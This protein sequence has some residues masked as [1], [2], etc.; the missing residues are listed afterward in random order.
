MQHLISVSVLHGAILQNAQQSI[1]TEHSVSLQTRP[2]LKKSKWSAQLLMPAILPVCRLNLKA[3]TA[4]RGNREVS[5]PALCRWAQNFFWGKSCKYSFK[6]T[7]SLQFIV[8]FGLLIQSYDPSPATT[9][10]S[11]VGIEA[12]RAQDGLRWYLPC[13]PRMV[14][15]DVDLWLGRYLNSE[16][17]RFWEL[18]WQYLTLHCCFTKTTRHSLGFSQSTPPWLAGD[19]CPHQTRAAIKPTSSLQLQLSSEH[20]WAE[21]IPSVISPFPVHHPT[22]QALWMPSLT[23]SGIECW[24]LNNF[25]P[26]SPTL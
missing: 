7:S 22:A 9:K 24:V 18:W 26:R 14:V 2:N 1:L 8:T 16:I 11:S 20:Y 19:S 17:T 3:S 5:L 15:S 21:G 25:F 23:P 6:S 13:S 10:V 12:G 4:C